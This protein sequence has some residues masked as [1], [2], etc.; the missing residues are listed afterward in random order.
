MQLK[1]LSIFFPT[2]NEEQNIQSQLK[3]ALE[4]IPTLTKQFELIVVDDGST[5]K[6][7]DIVKKMM[8]QHPQI[9]LVSHPNNRGYGAALKS[10]FMS[11]QYSWIFFTDADLQFNLNELHEFIPFT[12]Q[13]QA[14]L[15]YR[16]SRAEGKGRA[17]NAKLFKLFIDLLFRVHVKDIDCAFKL[18]DARLIRSIELES[19]GAFISAEL[20]YKLKKQGTI[21]KQIPVTHHP[22][23]RGNPTGANIKVIIKAGL[24][25]IKLYLKIKL[26]RLQAHQW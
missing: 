3:H 4:V 26:H 2:Y 8:K 13:Y 20:L 24:E 6:T 16:R 21:F 10:G 12:A 11:A 23:L 14:I 1:N 22:R 9:R 25:A 19:N 15:G 18:F 7:A 5:D 17:F